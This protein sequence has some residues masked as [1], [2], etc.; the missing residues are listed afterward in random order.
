MTL[1]RGRFPG[2]FAEPLRPT[3]PLGTIGQ[4]SSRAAFSLSLVKGMIVRELQY[5]DF[6]IAVDR[7]GKAKWGCVTR[8]LNG[9]SIKTKAG[10]HRELE[11]LGKFETAE[12]AV[13]EAK[14]QI[15]NKLVE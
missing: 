9:S 15:D 6:K 14:R 3:R 5:K 7:V 12:M 11:T 2:L 4:P 8:K 10:L 1:T 13:D